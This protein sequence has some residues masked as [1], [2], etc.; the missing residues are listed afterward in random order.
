MYNK[1]VSIS[2]GVLKLDAT[3]NIVD[4]IEKLT[5]VYKVSMGIYIFNRRTLEHIEKGKYLI[6]RCLLSN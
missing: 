3:E 1:D 4:Y 6:S 2:R 5:L